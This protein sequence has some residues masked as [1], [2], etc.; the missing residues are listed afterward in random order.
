[1]KVVYDFE[2]SAATAASSASSA[3]PPGVP[4]L[5][6]FF[7]QDFFADVVS[8]EDGGEY[9]DADLRELSVLGGC[10]RSDPAASRIMDWRSLNLSLRSKR[11]TST[12]MR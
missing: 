3:S 12:L 11:L 6:E 7:G 4:A 10:G 5:P 8:L 1:M 9:T 2:L